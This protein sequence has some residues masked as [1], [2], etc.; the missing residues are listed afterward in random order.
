MGKSGWHERTRNIVLANYFVCQKCQ[1]L[2]P[3]VLKGERLEHSSSGDKTV[4]K[5]VEM[6]PDGNRGP[7]TERVWLKQTFLSRNLW[8][9]DWVAWWD[10]NELLFWED[11]LYWLEFPQKQTVSKKLGTSSLFR[12]WPQEASGKV[13]WE[14]KKSM[15][16]MLVTGLSLWVLGFCPTRVLWET[17][18]TLKWFL[19]P[20][21]ESIMYHK[22]NNLNFET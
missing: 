3:W 18:G 19:F 22:M 17:R 10:M 13:R 1:G 9:I 16:G 4:I 20:P 11:I 14:E 21:L 8:E 5:D 12:K 15:K 7:A 6:G 2:V